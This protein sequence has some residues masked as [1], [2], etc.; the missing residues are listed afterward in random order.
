MD[1]NAYS[2]RLQRLCVKY[3]LKHNFERPIRL[4]DK[5]WLKVLFADLLWE[6]NTA[7]WL[8]DLADKLKRTGRKFIILLIMSIS[9]WSLLC[10]VFNQ[11]IATN[12]HNNMWGTI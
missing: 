2:V 8:T 5:P 12:F 3:C 11:Y 9:I 4:A 10:K 6:K 1:Q 7:E